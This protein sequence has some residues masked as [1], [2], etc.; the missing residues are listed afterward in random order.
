TTPSRTAWN[1]TSVSESQGNTMVPRC[2]RC[3]CIC[4]GG[5]FERMPATWTRP[6]TVGS[7]PK[8]G[9]SAWQEND[10]SILRADAQARERLGSVLVRAGSRFQVGPRPRRLLRGR[11]SVLL[12][13]GLQ[14]MGIGGADLLDANS[15]LRD[16][17]LV[18]VVARFTLGAAGDLE[19]IAPAL[20]HRRVHT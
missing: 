19:G 2:A 17:A 3:D 10:D 13:A 5:S 9:S 1:G 12:A 7:S 6:R 16:A 4:S 8:P 20:R 11:L 15:P 14:R 18:G